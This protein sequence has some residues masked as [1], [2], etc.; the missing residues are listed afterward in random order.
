MATPQLKLEVL[1]MQYKKHKQHG[2]K[3]YR[4]SKFINS[5]K[6]EMHFLGEDELEKSP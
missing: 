3:P 4:M 5:N 6:V 2:L 1:L